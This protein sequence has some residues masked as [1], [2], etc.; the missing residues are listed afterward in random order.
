MVTRGCCF[1]YVAYC[2]AC[3]VF[4]VYRVIVGSRRVCC[5]ACMA[6]EVFVA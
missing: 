6:Y 1:V 2:V 5:V 4:G 3:S